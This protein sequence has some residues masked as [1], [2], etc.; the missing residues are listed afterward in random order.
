MLSR[1]FLSAPTDYQ[2]LLLSSGQIIFALIEYRRLRFSFRDSA[3]S[4]LAADASRRKRRALKRRPRHIMP[5]FLLPFFHER[6]FT[7]MP[8]RRH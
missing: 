1:R 5:H 7:M 2:L 3:I 6:L 4:F 8:P